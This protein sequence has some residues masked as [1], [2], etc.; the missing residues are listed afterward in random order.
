MAHNR[1][2]SAAAV[3]ASEASIWRGDA[4]VA[5]GFADG[6][7]TLAEAVA[8]LASVSARTVRPRRPAAS[9]PSK[10]ANVMTTSVPDAEPPQDD[11]IAEPV[12]AVCVNTAAA[13]PRPTTDAATVAARLRAEFAEIATVAAQA[14]R[15]G[16]EIDAADA[17]RRGLTPDALRQAV[18]D[19]LA[20]QSEAAGI[21]VAASPPATAGDSPIVK[22]ARERAAAGGR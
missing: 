13:A 7:G 8:G 4:A 16:V 9:L 12:A 20:A 3:R 10:G 18:L 6:I 5:A 21:V 2:L 22:R 1:G 11:P 17:M 15:L 19:Q 14:G